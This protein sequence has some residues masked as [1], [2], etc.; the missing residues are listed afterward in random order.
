M[1]IIPTTSD[2]P[3][4]QNVFWKSQ[5][6][7]SNTKLKSVANAVVFTGGSTVIGFGVLGAA[8]M[9]ETGYKKLVPGEDTYTQSD[10][11]P[12]IEAPPQRNPIDEDIHG[13][14]DVRI[15]PLR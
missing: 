2:P 4:Q 6:C 14:H 5:G 8:A 12:Q 1:P 9:V 3:D 15:G 7:V 11:D 10:V 13:M